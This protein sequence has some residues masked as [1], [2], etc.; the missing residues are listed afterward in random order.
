[1]AT[2]RLP[3]KTRSIDDGNKE[4]LRPA[5]YG[6]LGDVADYAPKPDVKLWR[7]VKMS[8]AD[9]TSDIVCN[10]HDA[11]CLLDKAHPSPELNSVLVNTVSCLS[12]SISHLRFVKGD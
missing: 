9:L 8:W 12:D 10:D 6:K 5:R 7:L 1:M 3:Q 4:P 2:T 11:D